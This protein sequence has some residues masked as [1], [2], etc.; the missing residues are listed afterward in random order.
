VRHERPDRHDPQGL[1]RRLSRRGELSCTR[2]FI[3]RTPALVGNVSFYSNPT[4]RPARR[5]ISS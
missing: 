2:C 5:R 1:V 4:F 3:A